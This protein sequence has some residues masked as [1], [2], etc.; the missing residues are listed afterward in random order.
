MKKLL[1][2]LIII[3]TFNV[4]AQEPIQEFNFNGTLHNTQ[5]TITFMGDGNYVMDRMGITKSAQRLTNKSLE[6]IID[7]LPQGSGSRTISIWVK[8][9]DITVANYIWGYGTPY[10]AQYCGLLHQGTTTSNANLNFAGWGASNDIIINV[11]IA[12]NTWY[13][14]SITF[15]GKVSK[16]YRNG[17]LLKTVS[18]VFRDTKGIIFK[19]GE[20]NRVVG[21]NADIDDLKIYDIA[22]SDEEIVSLYNSSK[23]VVQVVLATAIKS[24]KTAVSTKSTN[25]SKSTG[26]KTN[27]IAAKNIEV[28]SQGQ[29]VLNGDQQMNI[30]ELPEGTY[31][32]KIT[33]DTS[34]KITAK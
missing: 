3:V 2:M 23:P 5:N 7:N 19:L 18:G 10:N 17:S 24:S 25:T 26:A 29:K 22:L 30:S 33:N 1:L 31:L 6:A 34:K 4:D 11:D 15:D 16:I 27:D 20:V 14:Y 9:N 12:K 32:L 28:F 8:M 13:Q 21:I